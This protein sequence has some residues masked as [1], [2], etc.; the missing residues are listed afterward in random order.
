MSKLAQTMLL[1]V[2]MLA[3]LI[4]AG[5]TIVRLTQALVPLVLVVGVVVGALRLAWCYSRRW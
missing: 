5:P 4:T 2:V 3:A 1:G